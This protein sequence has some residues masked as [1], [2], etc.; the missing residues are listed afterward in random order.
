MFKIKKSEASQE[1]SEAVKNFRFDSVVE[2]VK[3]V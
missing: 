2:I 1:N 3:I